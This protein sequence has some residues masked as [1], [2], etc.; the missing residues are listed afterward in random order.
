MAWEV[1][2]MIISSVQEQ[3]SSNGRPAEVSGAHAAATPGTSNHIPV[4]EL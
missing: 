4:T 1:T 3:V 2:K